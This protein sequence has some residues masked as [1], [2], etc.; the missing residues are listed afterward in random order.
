M[1]IKVRNTTR[2]EDRSVT[3]EVSPSR[4]DIGPSFKLNAMNNPN[5]KEPENSA[6]KFKKLSQV[7]EDKQI[8]LFY[9]RD[10]LLR[11]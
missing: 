4:P 9:L 10:Q 5:K 8:N 7:A 2:R 11:T 6:D 1:L 3:R